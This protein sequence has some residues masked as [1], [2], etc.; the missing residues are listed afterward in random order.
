MSTPCA[1]AILVTAAL[2]A[3]APLRADAL[4]CGSKLIA[5]GD[6]RAAVAARCG[7]PEDVSRRTRLAPAV[8]W[9][10]G[11]PYHV[12]AGPV[13]VVIEEWTYNFGPHR[14]MRRVRFEDGIVVRIDTLGYGHRSAHSTH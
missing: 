2:C 5:E 1:A 6:A 8:I 13:E 11:H 7:P 14:L 9:R 12:G 10:H 4:R 3:A